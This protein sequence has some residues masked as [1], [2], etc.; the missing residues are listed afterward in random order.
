MEPVTYIAPKLPLTNQIELIN[1]NLTLLQGAW[2]SQNVDKLELDSVYALIQMS[3]KW[4]RGQGVGNTA[5]T[6]T[7]WTHVKTE[8]G[9]S[10][11]KYTKSDFAYN[12]DNKLYFDGKSLDYRGQASSEAS[13][14]FD[15]VFTYDGSSY[16]DRS[17]EA[18]S[19]GGTAFS[20]LADAN[21]Y[22]YIGHA[23][24]FAGIDF[25]LATL[26][27]GHTLVVEY[28][29]GSSAWGIIAAATLDD[30]TIA[31]TYSGKISYAVPGDWAI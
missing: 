20:L 21:D 5:G 19:E 6:Y 24:Q 28:S 1:K 27:S 11:W 17:T 8:P 12:A 13:T 9:Y 22:I 18:G 29:Q 31:L 10:I 15:T 25:E 3:R 14:S 7:G 23:S 2:E 4:K 30:N 26:G 16:T